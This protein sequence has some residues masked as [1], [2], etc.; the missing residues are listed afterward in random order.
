[1]DSDNLTTLSNIESTIGLRELIIKREP[2]LKSFLRSKKNAVEAAIEALLKLVSTDGDGKTTSLG[3]L[4]DLRLEEAGVHKSIS[5]Y[6]EK[7]FTRLGYQAGAILDCL[8]YFRRILEETHLNNL[9]IR[10]C[11]IYLENDFVLAGLKALANFTYN[12][13]MPYLNCIE[14]SDQNYLVEVLPKLHGDLLNAKMDTLS[15]FKVEWDYVNMANHIPTSKLDKYL[16]STMCVNA[17]AGVFL[18]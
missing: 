15:D 10:S 11:R 7:R 18:Q 6:R 13:T 9:L 3:S 4:F 5:L 1:M 16:I 8:P 17:A 14:R 2:Y 12:V